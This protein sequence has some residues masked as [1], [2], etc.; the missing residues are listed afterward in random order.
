MANENRTITASQTRPHSAARTVTTTQKCSANCSTTR[1]RAACPQPLERC[2][3]RNR[4]KKVS[5]HEIEVP[6]P[7]G[8]NDSGTRQNVQ[9]SMSLQP[10][11]N[12]HNTKG[13]ASPACR[14]KMLRCS[15]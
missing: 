3:P 5:R 13:A 14:N 7:D 8:E 9:E 10:A 2:Q 6:E 11:H 12:Q 15:I 4:R 1:R